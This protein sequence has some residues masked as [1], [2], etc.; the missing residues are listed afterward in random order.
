MDHNKIHSSL[1]I[2]FL[3]MISLQAAFGSATNPPP[4]ESLGEPVF[5][6][7]QNG[8]HTFRIPALTIT[9]KGTVLAFAEARRNSARDTGKID[10]CVRRSADNGATWSEPQLIWAESENTCGNPVPVVDRDTGEIWLLMTWNLGEDHEKD[11]VDQSS[12]DTRRVFVTSSTDD[13]LSWSK[14]HEITINVKLTNWTWYATGP[15]CGIQMA[16]GAHKGRLVV[17][18]DHIEAETKC[19]Y[20]HVIYSDDH[21]KTWQLGGS[22]IEGVNECEVVELA[23]GRLMLNMRNANKTTKLRQVALSDDGGATWHDQRGDGTLIEPVCQGAIRRYSW[24]GQNARSIILFSNPASQ[25]S[26]VNMT[27]RASFDEGQTWP[28]SRVLHAGPSAYSD[29]AVLA[30]G[31]IACLFEAGATNSYESIVL[32]RLSLDSLETVDTRQ[33]VRKE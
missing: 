32:S 14:P 8:Y 9:T 25:T 2:S 22:S 28:V 24:P 12:K 33:G 5:A 23:G 30:N 6:R 17:A 11:I 7:G 26:R 20:S 18:C 3:M 4:A 10:L 31:Q 16:N 27:I 15:G 21:G 29:L 19:S 1:I 13:G